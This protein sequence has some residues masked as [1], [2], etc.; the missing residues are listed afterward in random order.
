[1][2]HLK[3]IIRMCGLVLFL[4]LAVAGIGVLG[5]APTLT[6]DNKLFADI[7]SVMEIKE[8]NTPEFVLFAEVKE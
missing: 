6:K 7:E 4:I 8:E 1:M 5:M 3:K 2:K